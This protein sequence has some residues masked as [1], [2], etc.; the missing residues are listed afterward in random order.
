MENNALK[1]TCIFGGGA[2]RGVSYIGALKAMSELNIDIETVAGASVGAVIA[3]LVA[4]GYNEQELEQIFMDISFDLFRDLHFGFGKQFALSKGELFLDWLRELIEKKYYGEKYVKG[5]NPRVTFNDLTKKLVIIT[6][7]LTQFKSKE[8]SKI[9]T[10]DFE[11]ALAIRISSSM[12]GLMPSV[13]HNNTQLVDGDLLKSW[14]LWKLS[15]SLNESED[16]ILEFRLEGDYEGK[17]NN[18][19]N[20]IN[21][22]YSCV[23]SAATR[24]VVDIYG[25]RDKYDYVIINTGAVVIVDF[26]QPANKRT[27]LIEIGYN[28]TMQHFKAFLPEKKKKL[29]EKYDIILKYLKKIEKELSKIKIENAKKTTGYLFM[30]LIEIKE[31]LDEKIFNDIIVLKNF[32]IKELIPS[33]IFNGYSTTLTKK[34]LSEV[35]RVISEVETRK[36]ELSDYCK[37]MIV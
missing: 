31:L 27:E 1:Y 24:F 7:D 8:F 14:P 4:V 18:A 33:T 6:T 29:I 32:I 3:G 2:I 10:P 34:A 28:Q 5:E 25:N 23:T 36:N 16:R 22:V 9:E 19:I 12:P 35:R 21:T 17:G 20:F 37:M 13:N 11:V 15:K 26:N 30:D